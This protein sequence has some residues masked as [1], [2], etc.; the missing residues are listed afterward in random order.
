M[1]QLRV[2]CGLVRP[3]FVGQGSDLDCHSFKQELLSLLEVLRPDQELIGDQVVY[4]DDLNPT[5]EV[6]RDVRI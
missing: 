1:D 4:F 6:R 5:L 3:C 2:R